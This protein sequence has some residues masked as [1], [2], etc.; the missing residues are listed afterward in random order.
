MSIADATDAVPEVAGAGRSGAPP[1]LAHIVDA[2]TQ[3]VLEQFRGSALLGAGQLSLVGLEAVAQRLGARWPARRE[4]VYEHAQKVLSKG[5][6]PHALVQRISEAE[7][8]V[9]E[10]SLPRAAGQ[11]RC[12]S[13]LREIL[14]HFLGEALV[15]DLQVHE[16]T[17]ITEDGVFGQR[18]DVGAVEKAEAAERASRTEAAAQPATLDRWTP[19]TT[20]EGERIGVS[21]SLEPVLNLR[22][23]DRI[24]YRIASRVQHQ[25]GFG[26]LTRRE[27]QRLSSADLERIDFATLARGLDR[28]R[29]TAAANKPLTLIAPVSYATLQSRRGRAT[30]IA[31]LRQA[32]DFVRHGVICE[33]TGIEG[34]PAAQLQST[35]A[36]LAPFCLHVV[37][38]LSD[39]AVDDGRHLV[40]VGLQGVTARCPPLTGAAQFAGWVK[41]FAK[42]GARVSRTLM[43]Y[44]VA[45][46][47]LATIAGELG[48]THVTLMPQRLKVHFIDDEPR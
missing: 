46:M 32:R 6:G 22:N 27:F 11:L 14:H 1:A 8:L 26:A 13:C 29:S 4:L 36:A 9:A 31:L 37:G 48:V 16:V 41:Q 2:G 15:G 18:L 24:G 3:A 39:L 43:L 23:S 40:D 45:D 34:A 38:R 42:V 44:Q 20:T 7:Y 25:P 47:P 30:I 28:I 19:F 17:R 33:L 5:M 35:I 10:P 12:L 21:C